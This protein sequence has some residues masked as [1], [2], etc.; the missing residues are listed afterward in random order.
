MSNL[1]KNLSLSEMTKSV[2][3]IRLGID[4]TPTETHLNNMK[5]LANNV[6]QPIRDY[7]GKPIIISSGYRSEKLNKAIGGSLTSQHSKGEAMD[8]DNDGTS[9]SNKEIFD[10]IKDNLDFDQLIGEGLSGNGDY[11]WIHVSY[12]ATRKNRKE[13]LIADFS[14]GKAV[15]KKYI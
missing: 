7:F 9:V 8:I 15:Y 6:F 12:S 5:A 2:T 3:A 4:N 1:S 11:N 13:I 10:F 14:T